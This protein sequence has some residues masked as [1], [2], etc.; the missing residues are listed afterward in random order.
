MS[1]ARA[2]LAEHGI[3]RL[4][5][6]AIA[7]DANIT[8]TA[9]YRHFRNKQDLID[10][11]VKSGYDQLD[12]AMYKRAR[13]NPTDAGLA[14]MVD[15]VAAYSL[16]YPRLFE[17]MLR[18]GSKGVQVPERLAYQMDQ[19]MRGPARDVAILL[20]AQMRGVLAQEYGQ[21]ERRVRHMYDTS[22]EHMRKSVA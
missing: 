2:I 4:T 10:Q 12:N 21:G 8:P 3:R 1:S 20:W 5:M 18:P 17:L 15:E 16:R 13:G 7:A 6:R 22:L 19:H 9:I 14:A 11:L